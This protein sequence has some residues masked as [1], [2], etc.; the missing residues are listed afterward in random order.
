MHR[1][2][3]VLELIVRGDVRLIQQLDLVLVIFNLEVDMISQLSHF[4]IKQS[5]FVLQ[6]LLQKF[7]L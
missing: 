4:R 3:A 5:E 2:L 6:L 7:L 1:V